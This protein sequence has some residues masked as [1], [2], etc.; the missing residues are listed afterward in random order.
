MRRAY[1]VGSVLLVA[2]T[3]FGQPQTEWVRASNNSD[4]QYRSQAF[5]RAKACYLEFRDLKQGTGYTTFDVDVD[6]I[7]TDLN[8][9]GKAPTK[10]D[11]EHIV[12]A[13][14]R[15]GTSRISNC[16]AVITAHVSFVQRH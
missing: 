5:E 9:E 10:T 3:L 11:T 15:T 4:I 13:P 6:Y 8:S 7:S 12:T 1:A 14:N 2:G 16:S